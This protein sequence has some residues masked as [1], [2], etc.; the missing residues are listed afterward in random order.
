[1]I[2]MIIKKKNNE[3]IIV[4]DDE[5][6]VINDEKIEKITRRLLIQISNFIKREKKQKKHDER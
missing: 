6:I 1:M 2:A 5:K 3:K 4:N